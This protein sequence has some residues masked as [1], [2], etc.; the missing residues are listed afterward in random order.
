MNKLEINHRIDLYNM[1]LG[2]LIA[3]EFHKSRE[4]SVVNGTLFLGGWL[5]RVKKQKCYP[6]SASQHINYFL[7]LYKVK[8]RY[9][10]LV[11]TFNCI[12][13]EL[14]Y[15][16]NMPL[17]KGASDNTRLDLAM[18]KLFDDG[19]SIN[20]P[21]ANDPTMND[22]YRP[23]YKKEVFTTQWYWKNA[24]NDQ[25]TLTKEISVFV[26]S[27]PQP[28]IDSLYSNG[29]IITKGLSTEDE[30]GNK[31]YQFILYPNNAYLGEVAFASHYNC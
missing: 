23:R 6:K 20:L 17:N 15:L 28:V 22:P 7:N 2:G 4:K 18:K 12:R 24:F 11:N 3:L 19:W 16:Y 14:S 27:D 31:Y 29:F 13:N 26:I 9:S 8:G 5:K 1:M 10:N 21:I 30:F 25:Q